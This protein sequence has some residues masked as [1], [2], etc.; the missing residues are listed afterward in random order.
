MKT[1]M[2]NHRW[3]KENLDLG[4]DPVPLESCYSDAH[5]QLEREAIFKRCWLIVGRV[6]EITK[7]GEFF[8]KDLPVAD[9][10][11]LV[12]RGMDGQ[13]RAFHNMCSHRA[14]KVVWD[15]RGT[16]KRYFTCPFHNWTYDTTGALRFVTDEVNFFNL[17]KEELGLT[18]VA[19]DVWEGFIF[20]N[21]DPR[22]RESLLEYMG[23]V[24]DQLKGYPFDQMQETY[25][26]SV[27]ERVNWKVLLDAQ[28]EVYHLPY[29]HKTTFPDFF[30][31]NDHRCVRNLAFRRFGRHCVY[32]TE[33]SDKHKVIRAEEFALKADPMSFVAA[34]TM[35][36]AFDFYT[37]FPNSVIGFLG[38]TFLH[39]RLWPMGPE[40]TVWEI[41]L[42]TRKP[43]NAG[44]VL[45][46]EFLKAGLRDTLHEDA[47][48]HERTQSVLKSGAKKHMIL[49]DEEVQIRFF[50]KM[51]DDHVRAAAG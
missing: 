41:R 14:N 8:V 11:V 2:G 36:G 46:Q 4:T 43:K 21:L 44:E 6:E 38:G 50:H 20:V 27:D 47:G 29:L 31:D 40:Q 10:S 39:Y 17:K 28:N 45:A 16:C 42:Y 33:R 51:V 30:A 18:P 9:T 24:A 5:Y 49:Q 37:I 25:G 7:P 22:P 15:E 32:S 12:V 23:G 26:Y 3:V 1:D 19:C 13:V 48:S 34:S 35:I